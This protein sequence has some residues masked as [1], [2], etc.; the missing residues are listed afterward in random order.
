MP[1]SRLHAQA[2]TPSLQSTLSLSI[3]QLTRL[4]FSQTPLT[5]GGK[6]RELG[7]WWPGFVTLRFAH[8]HH[9]RPNCRFYVLTV[10]GASTATSALNATLSNAFLTAG[11][12]SAGGALNATVT[13]R[14]ND[15][16]VMSIDPSKLNVMVN[17][18]KEDD[19][20]CEMAN[21]MHFNRPGLQ[22]GRPGGRRL[23]LCTCA[24]CL[25]SWC[26]CRCHH[27]VTAAAAH[28]AVLG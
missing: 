14:D 24:A 13:I 5:P 27:N 8:T 26:W 20:C 9:C 18:F 28:F 1:S 21:D 23:G 12:I 3:A 19:T 6:A 10:I 15:G 4:W 16:Q 25:T 22:V 7:V 11:A 2:T 17:R